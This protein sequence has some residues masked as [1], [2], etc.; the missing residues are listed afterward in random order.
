MKLKTLHLCIVFE[1]TLRYGYF[2]TQNE[3]P[4]LLASA[5]RSSNA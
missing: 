5:A 1:L 4:Y 2:Y 3:K